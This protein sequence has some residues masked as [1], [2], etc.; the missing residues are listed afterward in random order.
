MKLTLKEITNIVNGRLFLQSGYNDNFLVS[1]INT[2]ETAKEDEI[3]FLGNDKYLHFLK[4]TKALA[5]LVSKEIDISKYKNKNFIVVDDPQL[6]CS[7][8]LDII[9]EEKLSKIKVGI[10]PKATI[11]GNVKLGKNISIGHNV[12]IEEGS[13]VGDNTKILANVY[14]G[15]NVSIGKSCIIYPNVTI[16]ED[17]KIGDNCILNPGVVIG[18]EGFGF[19]SVGDKILKK[20]Q[21]GY[22][23]IG[24]NV[25]I[26][27]NT[28]VDRAT[29]PNTTTYI[30]DN[31]KIDNLVMIAHNVHIGK[32]SII[33]A[34]VG[35]AG[36]TKIG[37]KVT[38]GGQVG[39]AGH[40]TI[41]NNIMIGAKSGITCDLNDGQKLAGYPIQSYR[42]HLMSLA[43]IKKLPEMYQQLKKIIKKLNM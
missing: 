21:L 6:A 20:P 7:K 14:I 38:I 11:E 22:V 33:V 40:I 9:Y 36:S 1:G 35:V 3:A 18:G 37:D 13:K 30:G 2:L 5:I 19:V 23:E 28:T 34:Q 29:L 32:N 26:G 39:I 41:G 43:I 4:D 17:S 27:A 31:T 8:F 10:S 24:N 16:R 25:E 12:I 42:N 15:K